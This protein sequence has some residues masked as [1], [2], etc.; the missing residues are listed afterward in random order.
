MAQNPFSISFGKKPHQYIEREL[1]VDEILDELQSDI[2]Q[3]QCFMLTGVRGSGKT[4]T[5]TAIE[6]ELSNDKKWIVIGLNSERDMLKSLVAKLYDKKK[7]LKDFFETS[8]NLSA[9]GIGVSIKNVPPVADI[10]SALEQILEELNKKKMRLLVTIDEVSNTQGMREFASSMQ[11]MIRNDYP[12]FVIM[13]GL[14][15]NIHNLEDEKNLTFLYRAPKYYMEPLSIN[16]MRLRYK[17]IFNINDDAAEELANLTMGYPFAFQALGKYIWNSPKHKLTEEVMTQYD[18]ALATYVYNKIWDEMS[19]TDRWY[20]TIIAS[21][22]N[23]TVKCSDILTAAN[24]NK[25]EFSQYRVRLANKGIL[26]I[27]KRGYVTIGLPR[28]IEYINSIV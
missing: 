25:N 17:E 8:I 5:M 7:S 6:Q 15:E 12:I 9:F 18:N 14:Y 23:Q 3:N 19:D 13:S 21:L 4:V 16:L 27:S 28:F 11:L 10:E 24:K 1:I 20:M 26:D 2:I 22:D